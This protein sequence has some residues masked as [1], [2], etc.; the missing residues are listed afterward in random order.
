M[1]TAREGCIGDLLLSARKVYMH[2]PF[3]RE[4]PSS[5]PRTAY[6]N[7]PFGAFRVLLLPTQKNT[8]RCNGITSPRSRQAMKGY[9]QASI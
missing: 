9:Q 7:R 3:E 8:L 5:V 1:E 2:Y 4:V 6:E